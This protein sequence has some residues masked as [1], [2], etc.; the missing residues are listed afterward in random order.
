MDRFIHPPELDTL[1]QLLE[2]VGDGS[3]S[4]T[5]IA[6]ILEALNANSPGT[7]SLVGHYKVFDDVRLS[8]AIND[9]VVEDLGAF[10]QLVDVPGLETKEP[11]L[12]MV[13]SHLK[14]WPLCAIGIMDKPMYGDARIAEKVNSIIAGNEMLSGFLQSKQ[15]APSVQIDDPAE[16]PM[17]EGGWGPS[18]PQH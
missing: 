14:K 13:M 8:T 11:Y 10:I 17:P 1:Y 2:E 9:L 4:D 5:D 15:S 3:P 12:V 6:R 18:P 16:P 7:I